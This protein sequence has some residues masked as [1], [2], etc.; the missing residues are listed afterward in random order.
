MRWP[1]IIYFVFLPCLLVILSVREAFAYLDPG[2]GS[3]ILQLIT[4][5]IF[6]SM[7]VI[8]IYWGKITSL[9]KKKQEDEGNQATAITNKED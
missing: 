5:A 6:A 8:K 4:G 7:A 2:T 1:K 9:F 3:F